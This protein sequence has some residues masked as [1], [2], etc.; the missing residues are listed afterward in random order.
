MLRYRLHL[1]LEMVYMRRS[2]VIVLTL[3]LLCSCS[4]KNNQTDD[5]ALKFRADMLAAKSCTMTASITADYGDT[6]YDYDLG[7][8]H[9][10]N[11][12][13]ELKVIGPALIAGLT[14][15]L[16][17]GGSSLEFDNVSL[18]SGKINGVNPL[19]SLHET[20]TAWESGYIS[21]TGFEKLDDTDT[22]YMSVLTG[23]GDSELEYRSWFNEDTLTPIKAEIYSGE[24]AIILIEFTD[25]KFTA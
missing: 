20:M 17:D 19:T 12:D 15:K 5:L 1:I 8:T 4:S 21:Q 24:K 25:F 16:T 9:C 7:Y 3:M 14:A 23:S 2:L 22:L 18:Y 11:G 6:E 10:M 13:C